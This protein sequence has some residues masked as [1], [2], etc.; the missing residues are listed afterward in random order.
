MN[1]NSYT[2]MRKALLVATCLLMGVAVS[3]AQRTITGTVTDADTGEPLIGANVLIKGTSTGTV[4]DLDGNYSMLAAD[5]DVL[6][7]SYTGYS[8]QEVTVGTQ[9]TIDISMGAGELL[10][11]IVVIGYGTAKKSDLT[12]AVSSVS[13]EDFNRGVITSPDLLIQGKA[14][15][16][17]ILA[18][19]GQ[20]G[21]A[22]TIRIR[23]NTSIRA[24]QQPLFVVDGVPLSGQTVKPGLQAGDLGGT[25]ATNPLNFLNPADIESMQILKDASATAIYGSRGANGVVLIT[26]K[27]GRNNEPQVDF[28]TSIG[29]SNVLKKYEVL[30][31]AGYRQALEDYNL[32]TGDYGADNVDAFDEITRTALVT[33]NA[34][35]ISGGNDRGNYRM[36]T[37]YFKQQGVIKTNELSRLNISFNG[38]YNFLDNER[39]TIELGAMTSH[40]NESGPAISTNA[41]F[42][43]SLIGNALQWNPT[44]PLYDEN[45][46]P[47]II[48]EFGDFTNPVALIDAFRDDGK[49]FDVLANAALSFKILDNLTYKVIYGLNHGVGNRT[50]SIQPWINIQ[51]IQDRGQAWAID[52]NVTSHLLTHTLTWDANLSSSI[53]M[54]AVAGYEYN[55]VDVTGSFYTAQD[56]PD[57]SIDFTN[58]IQYGTQGSRG[59]GSYADP[60]SELQS[61]FG[62]FNFNFNERFLVTATVRADGSSKFG[63]NNKYGVFPAFALAWNIHNENFAS[64][65]FFNN[66]KFRLG[67]GQTGNSEFPAGAAQERYFLGD[68]QTAGQSNVANPDLKWET[69]TTFNVGFDY[70]F[71]NYKLYGSLEYFNR[72]TS[73]LLFQ[74]SAIQ[75]AP[76]TLYWTNLDGNVVN[77]GVELELNWAIMDKSNFRWDLGVYGTWLDNVFKDYDGPNLMY[78]TLFGQGISGAMV[79]RLDSDQPLNAF[80]V[81]D[82]IGIGD[83]G[84]DQFRDAEGNTVP[85]TSDAFY[86]GNPNPNMLL[87]LTTRFEFGKFSLDL[88]FNG[89]F[90]AD[91]YNN[92]KN[93]VI[94][95]GNLGSRNVDASLVGVSPQESTANSVK[96]SSRYLEK[97]D[98]MKLNN[99]TFQWFIG[100]LGNSVRNARLYLT[101]NNLLVF[102]GYSGFDPEVNTVND[103][104]GLPSSGIEYIPYPSARSI[105]LGFTFSL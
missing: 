59:L 10:D 7:F 6:I 92:T 94:P 8:S 85:A 14:P 42:R 90:G 24:G 9:E 97:G 32:T 75:P 100:N 54:N 78:G 96:S 25:P 88:N 20:P 31:G 77:S 67:W 63:E 17:Q 57:V 52:K 62:R 29:M 39:L 81:R 27:R 53:R 50:A 71:L 22:A 72:N 4:T 21:T 68:N 86:L 30:D 87:G 79:H 43:G 99:A 48:P 33:N 15:G 55:Q 101:G 35:S 41:G 37:G 70:A 34:L 11:E 76:A 49:T 64:G 1:S 65:G 26:T 91:I 51:N 102:T 18:N 82:W 13:E 45:G 80:Y 69:T 44:H 73:D 93:T 28:T 46:E 23:G 61:Y 56:F 5:A 3:M 66:L 83:E 84:F 103:A 19:S 47:I 12:G 38:K 58:A 16:I 40:T 89:A 36:S 60:I 98:Y 95:I 2:L 105:I 104:N 74:L